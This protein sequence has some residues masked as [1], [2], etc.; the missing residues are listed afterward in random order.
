VAYA[1]AHAAALFV[2]HFPRDAEGVFAPEQL[3]VEV[4]R[5]IL[6]GVRKHGINLTHKVTPLRPPEEDVELL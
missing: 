6:S 1:T 5:A 3:P 2:K 4:R